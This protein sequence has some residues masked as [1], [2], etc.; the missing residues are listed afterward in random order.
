MAA[1]SRIHSNSERSVAN[2]RIHAQL[3]V[4]VA[5]EPVPRVRVRGELDLGSIGILEDALAEVY[6]LRDRSI[7]ADL[8]G[9]TFIDLA[10]LSR[11]VDARSRLVRHGCELKV[12]AMSPSLIRLL[13]ILDRVGCSVELS[14]G[15]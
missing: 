14:R 12:T 9:L 3:E 15:A 13:D 11:I 1:I 2:R 6:A 5:L 10:G 4:D 7:A 8:S